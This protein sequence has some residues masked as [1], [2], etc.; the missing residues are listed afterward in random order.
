MKR[1]KRKAEHQ[2]HLVTSVITLQKLLSSP[3]RC[4]RT[5]TGG[6]EDRHLKHTDFSFSH[7]HNQPEDAEDH[8]HT[9]NNAHSRR[10]QLLNYFDNFFFFFSQINCFIL[11]QGCVRGCRVKLRLR[12]QKSPG[13][14]SQVKKCLAF[15]TFKWV[16]YKNIFAINFVF[17]QHVLQLSH[18][19]THS[20]N[21]RKCPPIVVRITAYSD[22]AV[23]WGG[24]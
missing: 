17:N 8:S 15:F 13:I 19:N 16:S 7:R 2:H 1:R 11:S 9:V 12:G 18:T 14:R 24:W 5:S 23:K 22:P 3:R 10:Q 4:L 21:S 20:H 6:A